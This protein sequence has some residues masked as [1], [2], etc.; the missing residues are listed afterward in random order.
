MV[1]RVGDRLSEFVLRSLTRGGGSFDDA[2]E[3]LSDTS[4]TTYTDTNRS[5]HGNNQDEEDASAPEDK[6]EELRRP[7]G[8]ATTL[9][10]RR[11]DQ[12]AGIVLFDP[13]DLDVPL[14]RASEGWKRKSF[15]LPLD[16][17]EQAEDDPSDDDEGD[18]DEDDSDGNQQPVESR[19]QRRQ[20]IEEICST[21][22][23]YVRDIRTLHDYY[24]AALEDN[25]HPIMEDAQIAVFFNN[26]R[27]LVML[28]SKLLNDLFEIMAERKRQRQ[29][30][31]KLRRRRELEELSTRLSLGSA[32]ARVVASTTQ[33]APTPT[34]ASLATE[35]IGAVFCR[36]APLFKLY[37]GYARDY[38]EV[39]GLL[40]SYSQDTRLGDFTAFLA[41]CKARSNSQKDFESLLIMPI[42]RIPRYKLL[43]E[44]VVKH[45]PESHPDSAFLQDAVHRVSVAASLIN[46]TV[47]DQ[48]NLASVLQ[49]QT[50][51]FSGQVALF[52][53]DRR[54]LKS[55]KL[56]KR[57]TRRQEEVVLHLFNDILLYS[58]GVLLT[59]GYRVRRVVD[60]KSKA[61]GVTTQIPESYRALF[62][63]GQQRLRGDCGFVVT[64]L[65]KTFILFAASPTECEEWVSAISGAIADAQAK[66]ADDSTGETPADAAALWVPDAV[67]GSCTIC[68]SVF[69]VYFRRHHC[70]R[71]GAVVCGN[72]SGKRS[73]LFKDSGR[74]ERV[75]NPCY[76][77]LD[78]V[79]TIAMQWLGKIVEFR[80]VLR[81]NRWNKWSEHYFELR[82]G[83]LRQYTLGSA[84]PSSFS[85]APAA[86]PITPTG[87]AATSTRCCT[88]TLELA[89]AIVVHRA[90]ARSHKNRFCFQISTSE[91]DIEM[92]ELVTTPYEASARS[93]IYL[94]EKPPT[95]PVAVAVNSEAHNS[96][97]M[98]KMS[99]LKQVV[100]RFNAAARESLGPA[101]SVASED[102]SSLSS[103]RT[104][105]L[106]SSP[107]STNTTNASANGCGSGGSASS[108]TDWILCAASYEEELR[109]SEALQR[110]ADRALSRSR[111]SRM[112]ESSLIPLLSS[113]DSVAKL[114][115][116]LGSANRSSC[117]GGD[118]RVSMSFAGRV[119]DVDMMIRFGAFEGGDDESAI[120]EH[121]RLQILKELIRSEESYVACLGECICLYVQPLLLR[122]LEGQKLLRRRQQ[123]KYKK[124]SLLHN[125]L[126]AFSALGGNGSSRKLL[127][128]PSP[129]S[130]SL[131]AASMNQR[132]FSSSSI[133][134]VKTVRKFAISPGGAAAV[135][136]SILTGA[137]SA[138]PSS[139]SSSATLGLSE[140][141]NNS[142]MS[143][144]QQQQQKQQRVVVMNADMAI[145]FSSVDQMCTLNQ[146]LLEQLS[147]HLEEI[148]EVALAT[149]GPNQ[150]N[151]EGDG[152]QGGNT[153]DYRAVHRAGAIFHAYAPL[154]QLY[155][156]YASRYASAVQAIESPQF[157]NFLRELPAEAS[158][159]RL[160]R[161]LNMPMERIPR[162]KMFLQELLAATPPDHIDYTPLQAAIRSVDRVAN[163]IRDISDRRD[164]AQKLEGISARVGIDLRGRGRFVRDGL[165]RKVCR[166]K[167]QNYYFVLLEDGTWRGAP[168]LDA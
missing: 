119:T 36:Y 76:R 103:S 114:Q 58:S 135:A 153:E 109:W 6:L 97:F 59:G 147:R 112:T 39:A 88:D 41:T 65:E 87:G 167:V 56:T 94:E 3:R 165:L 63:A 4:H 33:V 78:L 102:N 75:C 150:D 108:L 5:S 101:S 104:Q 11:H 121:R 47:R 123:S 49:A 154:L 66:H 51:F 74:E 128:S 84:P 134:S 100:G 79:K 157:T 14:S 43:L 146:Q 131:S 82:R 42:Q 61:V 86:I 23:S 130:T 28:N 116:T 155:T 8:S 111:R 53:A 81:R 70:R 122:Q 18:E 138:T 145:F 151:Q 166:S 152:A 40:R 113:F 54:L 117:S 44:R 132:T 35:G 69:K 91:Y 62:D 105:L 83:V 93:G 9:S 7:V 30:R 21:E 25:K 48:E 161:Y 71:C 26:L 2:S 12:G 10:M 92:L 20:V 124:S 95:T 139:S 158:V 60:L 143:K 80:G 115:S 162:Y 32:K 15:A 133:A 129:S 37:G 72:C 90:D 31:R 140:S 19:R 99:P 77:V 118:T 141:S 120:V 149:T 34:A 68:R 22:Q 144:R 98:V 46:E 24:I 164:S 89:G 142:N 163:K 160:R 13:R 67:A 64:S 17:P 110:S 136:A 148:R 27:Q 73:I 137:P 107:T 85:S 52:T 1:C 29:R 126:G 50:Q 156:S 127:T 16:G 106:K 168:L 45:T 38:Q 96:N 55:G 125:T 159:T 57:S